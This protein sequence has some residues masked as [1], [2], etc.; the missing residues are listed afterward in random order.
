MHPQSHPHP[1]QCESSRV[2]VPPR[3]NMEQPGNRDSGVR[4]NNSDTGAAGGSNGHPEA[5]TA[6]R[7]PNAMAV[8]RLMDVHAQGKQSQFESIPV[9]VRFMSGRNNKKQN[10]HTNISKHNRIPRTTLLSCA[11]RQLA[12]FL[13]W[14]VCAHFH[15]A[16]RSLALTVR[17]ATLHIPL[18]SNYGC[19][20]NS[21]RSTRAKRKYKSSYDAPP[22]PPPKPVTSTTTTEPPPPER[23]Q[24]RLVNAAGA[25]QP[26]GGGGG[27]GI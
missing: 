9:L 15:L 26:G 19:S 11:Q 21:A 1:D 7:D 14:C 8:T 4:D 13:F 18:I 6:D 22:T 2:S 23:R 3:I 12:P 16:R 17:R 27:A 20:V 25:C 10:T 5:G 24:F